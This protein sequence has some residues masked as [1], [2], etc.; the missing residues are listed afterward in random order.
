M[1]NNQNNLTE[2]QI[3]EQFE[4]EL[5]QRAEQRIKNDQGIRISARHLAPVVRL[6]FGD[7]RLGLQQATMHIERPLPN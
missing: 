7:L 4:R 1:A 5:L 6:C 2:A 3:D